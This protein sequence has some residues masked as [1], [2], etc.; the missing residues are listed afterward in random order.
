[1]KTARNY[2]LASV[3]ASGLVIGIFACNESAKAKP[4]LVHQDPPRPGV[5]AKINGEEITEEA[6]VGDDKLD[7]FD[8][9]K[10]EYELKMD[11]LNKLIVDKLVGDEAKK[12]NMP[13][14]DFIDK[15][16]AGGDIKISDKDY[17]KFVAEKHIP[18]AQIN[19][20]IKERIMAYLQSQKKQDL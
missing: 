12:A 10:R 18:E 5:L 15:K 17:K 4:N 6:L 14:N 16:V 7:F 8:L 20:Q 13:L 1:M 9:K 3:L 11:R 2:A 19:P